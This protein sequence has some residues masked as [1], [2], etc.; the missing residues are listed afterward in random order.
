[1]IAVIYI[2]LV[3]THFLTAASLFFMATLVYFHDSKNSTSKALV[4]LVLANIIWLIVDFMALSV[5]PQDALPWIRAVM[6]VSAANIFLLIHFALNFPRSSFIWFKRSFLMLLVV[7]VVGSGV[8]FF[9]V[10]GIDLLKTAEHEGIP[11]LVVNP[12]WF[13]WRIIMLTSFLF[14]AT[15]LFRRWRELLGEEKKW[16]QAALSGIIISYT[17]SVVFQLI[18]ATTF[19]VYNVFSYIPTILGISYSVFRYST[20]K[21]K[22]VISELLVFVVWLFMILRLFFTTTFQGFIVESG[23]LGLVVI[24]GILLIKSVLNEIREQEDLKTLGSELL[25]LRDNLE[26]RI[27]TQMEEV[28]RAYEVER[29]AR[30]DLEEL[31]EA[32]N[33]FILITQ[34]NLRTPLT[35]IKGYTDAILE[36]RIGPISPALMG[37]IKEISKSADALT[38]AVNKLLYGSGD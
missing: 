4:V 11:F 20:F 26:S 37:S 36:N 34:H 29:V 21:V 14:A 23:L 13:A 22:V 31:D 33:Q 6:L 2:T 17:L 19:F 28:K 1:M 25:D 5:L 7:F 35:I 27:V 12:A 38:R 10:E 3:I 30:E 32:K 24:F 18:S 9:A 8:A 16:W 15:L